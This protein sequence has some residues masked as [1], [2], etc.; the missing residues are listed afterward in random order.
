LK[1]EK[2]KEWKAGVTIS[3]SRNPRFLD[4]ADLTRNRKKKS[5]KY[6]RLQEGREEEEKPKCETTI[7]TLFL[8]GHLYRNEAR[9]T[10]GPPVGRY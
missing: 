4:A 2:P 1:I 8:H 6:Q 3:D 7:P 5:P 9:G 10:S